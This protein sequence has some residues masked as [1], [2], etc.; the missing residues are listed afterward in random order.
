[1]GTGSLLRAYEKDPES[2]FGGGRGG[3]G[4]GSGPEWKAPGTESESAMENVKNLTAREPQ[5][6]LQPSPETEMQELCTKSRV[7][8]AAL[9]CKT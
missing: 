1:M 3:L 4:V 9:A 8:K 2:G 6:L 7:G 5:T